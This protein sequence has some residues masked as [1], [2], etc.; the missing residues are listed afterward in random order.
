MNSIYQVDDLVK[1]Y[2]LFRGFNSTFRALELESRA[3]RDKGFQVDKIIEELFGYVQTSDITNLLEFWRYLD[4]RY[5]SRLDSRFQR[6]VKKFELC[7]LRYYLELILTLTLAMQV[8]RR[9]KV[10]EFFD[11][12]GA[13]LHEN[14]EWLKWFALPYSKN[15]T[16]DPAFETFFSKQWLDNYIV[17][18]H[19]FLN[20]IF[21]NMPLPSLLTLNL[22]KIQKKAQQTEIDALKASI[23][24]LK[25][26]MET[27]E[28]ENLSLKQK[29]TET[30][31]EMTDGM[32]RMRRRAV[33]MVDAKTRT[34][35]GS[36]DSSSK[37]ETRSRRKTTQSLSLSIPEDDAI[38]GP[39]TSDSLS[40]SNE[41]FLITTQEEFFEHTSGITHAKFSSNGTTIA[42]CDMDNIIRTWS[43]QD[44]L[45]NPSKI[46]NAANVLSL[47]WEARSDKLLLI[48]TDSGLIR[49]YNTESQSIVQTFRTD[50]KLPKVTQISCS[51]A[52]SVFVSAA[53]NATYGTHGASAGSLISWNLKTMQKQ[54][55]F[56][57]EGSEASSIINTVQYN[58]NGQ[59][60]VSGNDQGFIRIF[61][62]RTIKPIMEWKSE[63][64]VA[65]CFAQFS[66]DETSIM[67]VSANGMLTQWSVHKPGV[68]LSSVKLTGFPPPSPFSLPTSQSPIDI[69][70]N[71]P[72]STID[73]PKPRVSSSSA[74]RRSVSSMRSARL[75]SV[76]DT[77]TQTMLSVSPRP[78]MVAFSHDTEHVLCAAT[79]REN[80]PVV[81]MVYQVAHGEPVQQIAATQNEKLTVVDWTSAAN[82]CLTGTADG[83]IRVTKLIRV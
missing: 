62:A 39:S 12:Y 58:H 19:N 48:G 20:T 15:P 53:S 21:Q 8:K 3:D 75:P 35:V 41:A 25:A 26:N 50:E 51:P 33:S 42:S 23:D 56:E 64:Q 70:G 57:L 73:I 49:V 16:T 32:T 37:A 9:D 38:S 54:Q 77:Y 10:I 52:E 40:D 44:Q 83:S 78:Q 17:S 5:F 7:L 74:S 4:T 68:S 24:T 76:D 22:D 11:V 63:A 30:K 81:G 59:L 2:L 55:T 36:P 82:A 29:L 66:F 72:P 43:Y 31:K 18:L 27:L 79:E 6:T 61:D 80:G 69:P 47:E 1:E 14:S 60:L 34:S 71:L 46:K 13:E 28:G 67:D 65:T 45:S